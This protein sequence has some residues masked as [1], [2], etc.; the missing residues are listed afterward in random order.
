MFYV[1]F[2]DLI[3][4]E[5]S[6]ASQSD[7]QILSFVKV[8]NVAGKKKETVVKWPTASVVRFVSDQNVA[9]ISSCAENQLKKYILRDNSVDFRFKKSQFWPF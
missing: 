9:R 5:I 8:I 1:I 6:W 7:S 2:F 3:R 4:I